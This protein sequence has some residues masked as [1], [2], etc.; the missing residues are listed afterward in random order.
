MYKSIAKLQIKHI[1]ALHQ[2]KYRQKYRQ[3]FVEG[4]KSV[5]EFL[6]SSF[7]C[8]NIFATHE[9][10]TQNSLDSFTHIP[11]FSTS[12]KEMQQISTLK[13][14]P[15]ILAVFEQPEETILK[16]DE[17]LVLALD[18]IRDPGNLGTTIRT[19]EWFGL[20]QIVCSTSCAEV[21]NPKVVQATMGSLA[22]VE[23][24]Y[25]DLLLLKNNLPNHKMVLADMKGENVASFK[26]DKNIL[27]IGNEA[28][29]VSSGLK[30]IA[31]KT[32]TIPRMGKAE[33]LN[34]AISSG[35]ILA[36]AK[37]N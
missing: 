3:F 20:K 7:S 18:D 4:T 15:G 22:R 2:K 9:W 36:Y 30:Q 14:P 25:M 37:L 35:I 26:W 19:A 5:L 10:L 24:V 21:F 12:N 1:R 17:D 11:I 29:G 13:N 27:V 33:S 23:V 16:V 6:N 28:N 8:Q 34:A 31:E 32:L